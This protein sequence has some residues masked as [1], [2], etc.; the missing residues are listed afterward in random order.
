MD[1]SQRLYYALGIMCYAIAKADGTVQQEE[2]DE[3][4]R[5]VKEG[6]N[7][8]IDFSYADIIFQ[9]LQKDNAGFDE[10]RKWALDAL[11]DGKYHL[12]EN[13][14]IDFVAV[15]EKVAAAFP[16]KVPEEMKMVDQ[17]KNDLESIHV[18]KTID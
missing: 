4:A 10:V 16:P 18:N 2:K 9:I 17:F 12:T 7:H 14:K 8:Q 11:E 5:I 13:L 3:L 1:S 6:L 15:L